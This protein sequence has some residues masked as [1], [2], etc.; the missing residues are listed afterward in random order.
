MINTIIYILLVSLIGFFLLFMIRWFFCFIV[1]KKAISILEK[2]YFPDGAKSK[3]E[4]IDKLNII[5][6]DKYS[7]KQLTD[8]YLKIKGLQNFNKDGIN[9][10]INS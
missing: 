1:Q 4:F 8:Y 7:R 9:N 5:T 6:N 3:Q 2:K 10:L